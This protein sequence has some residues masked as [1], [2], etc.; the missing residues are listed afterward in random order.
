MTDAQR[1]VGWGWILLGAVL[2]HLCS[3]ILI[4]AA[5]WGYMLLWPP[6]SG[7]DA[8]SVAAR[9]TGLRL[10][11]VAGAALAF[12]FGYLAS[13]RSPGREQLAGV[14]VGTLAALLLLPLLP[15]AE[16]AARIIYVL[17]MA[18]KVL[19]GAAGGAATARRSRRPG[20]VA[21]VIVMAALTLPASPAAAA[22]DAAGVIAAEE[23]LCAA[24]TSG[25]IDNA[26]PWLADDVTL[27]HAGIMQSGREWLDA[28]RSGVMRYIWIE[29]SDQRVRIF[30]GTAV[31]T[32]R[33]ALRI[34]WNGT[35]HAPRLQYTSVYHLM[36]GRWRLVAYHS[37]ELRETAPAG[38]R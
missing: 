33:R 11:P 24:L 10:G 29:S 17:S 5:A 34:V 38:A 37:D 3:V 9:Q 31:L 20:V 19:A 6:Q 27:S 12:L 26:A 25:S 36:E 30:D 28:I 13:R 4:A 2:A 18:L 14:L 8:F 35:E 22:Q 23:S 7:P 1:R 16:P 32:G 15:G 21:V